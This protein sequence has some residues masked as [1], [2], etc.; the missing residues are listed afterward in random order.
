[1]CHKT[2]TNKQ[3]NKQTNK[4]EQTAQDGCK[5]YAEFIIFELLHRRFI[6]LIMSFKVLVGL[7]KSQLDVC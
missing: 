6:V 2:K 7:W 5:S 3:T 1:M 4:R